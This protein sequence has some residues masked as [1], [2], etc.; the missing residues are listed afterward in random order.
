MLCLTSNPSSSDFQLQTLQ[1]GQK[2]YEWVAQT[3]VGWGKGKKGEV[4]LV[5]GATQTQY[6]K[7]LR[8]LAPDTAFLVPGVGTQGGDLQGVLKEGRAGNGYGILVN[9]SRQV[10]YASSG[11]DYAQAARREAQKLVDEMKPYFQGVS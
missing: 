10:L 4:G 5:V 8:K 2:L 7:D 9:V 11:S 3:A 6:L 1:N